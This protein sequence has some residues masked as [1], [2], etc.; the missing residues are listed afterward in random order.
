[1]RHTLVCIKTRCVIDS[2]QRSIFLFQTPEGSCLE[3]CL[4]GALRQKLIYRNLWSKWRFESSL[5][6]LSRWKV[7]AELLDILTPD[8]RFISVWKSVMNCV[9]FGTS[10]SILSA[11]DALT[12]GGQEEG[13]VCLC[14]LRQLAEEAGHVSDH[15]EHG[16]QLADFRV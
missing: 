12:T 8:H 16:G 7:G 1:M 15:M 9:F 13:S 5:K 3:I 6:L 11:A 2:G 10:R 4:M 14:V